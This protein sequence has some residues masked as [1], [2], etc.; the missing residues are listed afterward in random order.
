MAFNNPSITFGPTGLQGESS[1]NPTALDTSKTGAPVLY[2]TQQDG[3]IYR[4]EIER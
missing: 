1:N 4:Y 2:V 3:S